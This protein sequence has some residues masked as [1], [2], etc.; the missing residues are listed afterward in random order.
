MSKLTG[1]GRT[2]LAACFALAMAAP[3]R[4]ET[5]DK[6]TYLTFSAPVHVPGA[7]LDPGTYRFRL[8]NPETTRNVLQVLSRDGYTVYAMFHT[9]PDRR[10]MMTSESTVTFRET[11]AGAAP[12]VK[13]LFYGG[14]LRGYEFVYPKDSLLTMPA[15]TLQQTEVTF[16]PSATVK[17][18]R[19]RQRPRRMARLRPPKRRARK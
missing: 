11:P 14:E 3:A 9:I 7:T 10:S 16:T 6:L 5:I 2:L 19:R 17:H 15:T 12:E 1:I 13:S 18:R 8:A 4:A